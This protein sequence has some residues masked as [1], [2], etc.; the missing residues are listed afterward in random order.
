MS[1]YI[2][3]LRQVVGHRTLI[4][5]AAA[6]GDRRDP[7]FLCWRNPDGGYLSSNPSGN[8]E[9]YRNLQVRS[10]MFEKPFT[11]AL[12]LRERSEPV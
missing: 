12:M 3:D 2:M 10:S 9:V 6:R 7:V 11:V 8:A 4:Q 1:G 5:A